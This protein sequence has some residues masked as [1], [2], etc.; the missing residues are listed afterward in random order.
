MAPTSMPW[1]RYV[2]LVPFLRQPSVSLKARE[3]CGSRIETQETGLRLRRVYREQINM[4]D[5]WHR[6]DA[7]S[8]TAFR[9]AVPARRPWNNHL[10]RGDI[11]CE[12]PQT[13]RNCH[14]SRRALARAVARDA[15][16][17]ALSRGP[18]RDTPGR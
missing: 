6:L 10:A 9:S 17:A 3:Q 8:V 16:N 4:V 5:S 1:L 2:P 11:W 15:A 13:T 7:H 18:C 12:C 14:C